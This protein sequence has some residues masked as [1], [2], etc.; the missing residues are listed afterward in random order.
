MVSVLFA[1][2]VGFT[3][4]A[5]TLDPENVK[6][7]VDRCFERLATDITTFGGVVDKIFGDG[8][9]ALFGA[10]VAHEDD[11][12][13]AV[14]AALRMQQTM[15]ALAASSDASLQL[16]IGVNTGE[17][18]VGMS[19][20]GGDYTAMGDV[21]NL[22]ARLE[23]LADPGRVLVGPTTHAATVDAISYRPFGEVR[24]RGREE[25][26]E[27][28][29]AL[30]PIRPPGARS[31]RS[32]AFVGRER[33]LAALHAQA[34]LAFD[35]SRA[36][37][38]MVLGE[39]G[40]GKT[41]VVQEAAATIGNDFDARV[42]E[43]RAV[44]Y[45]EANAWWPVA[46]VLRQ[47]F[48]LEV[49]ASSDYA[50]FVIN[51]GLT[52]HLVDADPDLRQRYA[53]AL[54][55]ALG[56]ATPLRGGDRDTNRAEVTLAFTALLEAELERR[57]VVL[58]M[59]DMHLAAEGVRLLLEHILQELGRSRLLLLLTAKASAPVTLPPGR[60]GSMM[61]PLSPLDD[62][63][64]LL[65]L[66]EFEIDLPE[67]AKR[68]IVER[69]G[70]NP[71]FLEELAGLVKSGSEAGDDLLAMV[72][73][74]EL[75]SMPDSLRGIIAARLDA[76]DPTLRSLLEAAA[77]FGPNG[78]VSGLRR[79]AQIQLEL[80]DIDPLLAEL[81]EADLLVIEGHRYEFRSD[82]VRDVAYATLTKTGRALTHYAIA[83]YLENLGP[84]VHRLSIILVIARHFAAASELLDGLSVPGELDADLIRDKALYWLNE[85]GNGSLDSGAPTEA[86][87]WYG[88]GVDR[89]EDPE[90]KAGFL[91]GRARARSDVRDL[92]GARSDLD[93]IAA[94]AAPDALL[95][96]RVLLEHGE[97]D[98]KRG[99]NERAVQRL[100]EAAVQ[101]D[102]L[103]D[104]EKE[105]LALRLLGMAEMGRGDVARAR[106]ALERSKEVA[107]AAADRRSEAWALQGLGLVAYRSGD[108]AEA[109]RLVENSVTIFGQLD[110]AGGTA[111]AK[112][113]DAWVAF[114]SGEWDRAR[115]LLAEV[116]PELRRRGDPWAEAAM[117]N[118]SASLDL[119]SGHLVD[120][121][122]HA[123]T[124][125]RLAQ[126]ADD[127]G[128][129]AQSNNL[130]GRALVSMGQVETGL[131]VLVAGHEAAQR[132]KSDEAVRISV[133]ANAGAAALLGESELA[134]RW[135]ARFDGEAPN[136]EI[137]G[138][139][140]LAVAV[141][142]ALLQRGAVAEASTHLRWLEGVPGQS[143]MNAR[144]IEAIIAAAS[145]DLDLAAQRA[146]EVV[147]LSASTYLDLAFAN[148]AKAAAHRQAGD[149]S[150][151]ELAIG[152][153]KL[154]VAGT[155]DA[156]MPL[157]IAMAE[158]VCGLGNMGHTEVRFRGL[159]LDPEG[160]RHAWSLA[161]AGGA[162][163]A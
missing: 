74:G 159:G 146:E 25:L 111:W 61:L 135:A 63:A 29:V 37:A 3:A 120:A 125:Q 114:H 85:A 116:G 13:R 66:D 121:L 136:P 50:E 97:I 108:L 34:R 93:Q 152:A 58:I 145:G 8:I 119:W 55:H 134:I 24:A 147:T 157:I 82:L 11:P 56:F 151:C 49:D 123:E 48:G 81:V 43:G 155:D 18:L 72:S 103:G 138:E 126:Q 77:V 101:L 70:G 83:T 113:I 65:M 42:I 127:P 100:S 59:T 36:H 98:R 89:A 133:I 51:T 149:L 96:A 161:V 12:E 86:E 31:R 62:D 142:L 94:I 60:Y 87:H 16:R 158:A 39:A 148:L 68:R 79:M 144:A 129:A 35:G 27:A 1:D 84:D 117:T 106:S 69:S 45:G 141:A 154:A 7:I 23:S 104:S 33:E 41:R 40:M 99:D 26:I 20:A 53:T 2:I 78:P 22:G 122:E 38:T 143:N 160:W 90:I 163:L 30:N 32:V 21:M 17:V 139:T 140:D 15:A 73:A 105:A 132:S 156:V 6:Q 71:L 131:A 28:W 137:L 64:A 110:D 130:S 109:R 112:G 128:L 88:L 52:A 76:L 162:V 91:Y 57:P 153:A 150:G 10:P 54:L 124:A 4:L 47:V 92:V 44:P 118:L 115:V 95:R 9:V 102:D 5:E 67:K 19:S 46:D 107:A 75:S 80:D 14:R